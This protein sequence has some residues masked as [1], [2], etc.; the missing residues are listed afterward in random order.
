MTKSELK[1]KVKAY[2]G[3]YFDRDTMRFFNSKLISVYEGPNGVYFVTYE[4]GPHGPGAYSVR[5]FTGTKVETVGEFMGHSKP[6]AQ[7]KAK[8]LAGRAAR[9]RTA[10]LR[11]APK[12]SKRR[13]R[14]AG[15]ARKRLHRRI[16]KRSR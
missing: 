3:H 5:H 7:Q 6:D 14:R 2:G 13:K 4:R 15:R 16:S 12:R 1:A 8:G 11:R 10:A 9:K